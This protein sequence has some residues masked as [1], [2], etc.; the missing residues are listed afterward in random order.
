[1]HKARQLLL[2]RI[3]GD[4]FQNVQYSVP[5]VV[6]FEY[7]RYISKLY[8]SIMTHHFDR[9]SRQKLPFILHCWQLKY[10]RFI[11]ERLRFV[12]THGLWS[13]YG[14][15]KG[16]VW[17]GLIQQN[18]PLNR[19]RTWLALTFRPTNNVKIRA[20]NLVM[21]PNCWDCWTRQMLSLLSAI[22][23][24]SRFLL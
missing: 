17:N 14:S 16:R 21:L 8:I 9:H 23:G 10:I 24:N 3:Y 13:Y 18:K 19:N 5:N 6:N 7:L 2:I 12:S 20:E 15:R 22:F 4:W 1:M 11:T